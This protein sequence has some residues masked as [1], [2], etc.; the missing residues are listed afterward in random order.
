MQI[1]VT[2]RPPSNAGSDDMNAARQAVRLVLMPCDQHELDGRHDSGSHA[3]SLN[4][5]CEHLVCHADAGAAGKGAGVSAALAAAAA[6]A[7]SALL[8]A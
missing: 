5:C 8:L 3:L 7:A 6:A 1:H 4:I 2:A